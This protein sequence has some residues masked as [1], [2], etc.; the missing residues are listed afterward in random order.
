M[1]AIDLEDVCDQL[2]YMAKVGRGML[3]GIP[4]NA[5][6]RIRPEYKEQDMAFLHFA[7]FIW[8]S[9]PEARK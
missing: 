6:V 4:P 1:K 2:E 3:E 8:A 5:E 7:E 9:R